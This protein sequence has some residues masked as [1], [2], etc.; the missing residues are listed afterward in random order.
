MKIAA[1]A[2]ENY[3]YRVQYGRS[4]CL[5]LALGQLFGNSAEHGGYGGDGYRRSP[6]AAVTAAA[7]ASRYGGGTAAVTAA[8]YGGYGGVAVRRR[9]WRDRRHRRRQSR[10]LRQRQQFYV[11]DS[12]GSGACGPAGR[13]GA[14]AASRRRTAHPAFGGYPRN[15]LPAAPSAQP[16][17]TGRPRQPDAPGAAGAA[18]ATQPGLP[19]PKSVSAAAHRSQSARQRTDDSGRRPAVSEHSEDLE[20]T[21]IPPRQI[22]LEAK[23]YEVDLTDQF[24]SGITYALQQPSGTSPQARPAIADRSGARH[25]HR[26]HAGRARAANCWPRSP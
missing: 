9:I 5:A 11:A 4:D 6:T 13:L 20:G 21:R 1:G 19:A 26:G 3:V 15:T 24:A 22:L 10:R 25:V 2:V 17:G 8:A 14:A 23:I 16:A 7:T 12:A 18:G